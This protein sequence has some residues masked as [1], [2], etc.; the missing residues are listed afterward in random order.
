MD[1]VTVLNAAGGR[2]SSYAAIRAAGEPN[3]PERTDTDSGGL[4][5][6]GERS[7]EVVQG[8]REVGAGQFGEP[9]TK[10]G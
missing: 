3:R 8:G 4:A 2:I 9:E 10:I 1:H 6:L 7:A 5:H